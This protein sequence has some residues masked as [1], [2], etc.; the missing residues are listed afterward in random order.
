MIVGG[1]FVGYGLFAPWGSPFA[2]VYWPLAILACA[3][4]L[5]IV[6]QKTRVR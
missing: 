1:A 4:L 5:R 2:I 3:A 6:W